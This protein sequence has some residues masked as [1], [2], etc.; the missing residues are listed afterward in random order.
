LSVQARDRGPPEG[1]NVGERAIEDVVSNIEPVGVNRGGGR[2]EIGVDR[3]ANVANA[4]GSWARV[5][6]PSGRR[7]LP[8]A[9]PR[10]ATALRRYPPAGR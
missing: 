4:L 1:G 7:V 8:T 10:S 5:G 9:C 3:A 2:R 6:S